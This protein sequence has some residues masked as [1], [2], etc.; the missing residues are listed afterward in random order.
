M[1]GLFKVLETTKKSLMEAMCGH[2]Q[3]RKPI[4]LSI[5]S[6]QGNSLQG[7]ASSSAS[8]VSLDGLR[9]ALSTLVKIK[10]RINVCLLDI[11]KFSRL[12]NPSPV[13]TDGVRIQ[14]FRGT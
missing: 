14:N 5:R 6:L 12:A 10:A 1:V 9:A 3:R 13:T 4:L 7:R 2:P 11:R 8:A